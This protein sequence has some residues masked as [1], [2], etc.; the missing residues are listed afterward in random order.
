MQT[1]AQRFYD[2]KTKIGGNR[3]KTSWEY[4]FGAPRE[5]LHRIT[6][7]NKDIR[8][9]VGQLDFAIRLSA[10]AGSGFD[11]QINGAL[12][13]LA[14][15]ID[16]EGVLTRTAC[17]EAEKAILP[18]QSAAKAYDIILASH[19]H[20]DMN[21][22]WGLQ[23][24]VA[25]TLSTF[26]TMLQLMREYP[27]FTFSQSQASVYKIVEDYDP[28]MMDEIK[29]RI[30]E[31]RWECTATAW[32]ETDKNMPNTESLLRHIRYTRDYM[33]DVWG[34]DPKALEVDFSP[35]TFGHAANIP[36]IDSYGN[37]K[38]YYHCRGLDERHVLYNWK[39]PSGKTLLMY[40][41]PYWYNSA[42]VPDIGA[43]L[44]DLSERC[45]GLKTGLIVY[46]VGD[47]GGG[48]TRRDIERALEMQQWPVFPA[49]KFGTFREFF[50]KA[51]TVRD[52]VPVIDKE[53]NFVSTGCYTT[54]SRIKMGNRKSEAALLDAEGFNAISSLVAGYTYPGDKLRRAWQNV[55]FTHF[56]DILTGSCVQESREHA[57]ALY[58]DA[59]SVANTSREN[60][61]RALSNMIDTSMIVVDADIADTQSEGAGVGY[62]IE[63]FS[64]V[65]SPEAG[66]GKVRIYN[67]FNPS[68][69]ERSD[70]VEITVWDWIGDL[71]RIAVAD[72]A[73]NAVPFQLLDRDYVKYWDHQYFRL[74]VEVTVP[75]TGYVT[76]VM[77]EAA[78][79][80]QYPFYYCPFP[81]AEATHP[82][83]TLENDYLKA[84][85]SS[86]D[87]ALLSLID[88]KTGKERIKYGSGGGRLVYVNAERRSN[89]AWRLGRLLGSEPV[90]K[91]LS[92]APMPAGGLRNGFVME[93]EIMS[94]KIVTTVALDRD[95]RA[96]SYTF[97]VN[98]H[99]YATDDKNV[100]V[101][102]YSLPLADSPEAY[103]TDV[104]AGAIRRPSLMNDVSGLQYAAAVYGSG[105]GGGV[106][107]SGSS[108]GSGSG[109]SGGYDGSG[110]AVAL[111]SDC[112][113]GYRGYDDTLSLTLI[114]SSARPDPYP[115]I[116]V[117]KANMW[118]AVDASCPK[119][120][121][122]V[123][124]EFCRPMNYLSTGCHKGELPPSG[125]LLGL[126]AVSTV[127]SSVGLD[128][129]GA[130]LVR[131]YETCGRADSVTIN[132]PFD[133]KKAEL[134]DLC[135]NVIG[136]AS[137]N[138]REITFPIAANS[139]AGARIS[140]K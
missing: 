7:P 11:D 4:T 28:G 62:G 124:A 82:P 113:Y 65:P 99:E 63:H 19:A 16:D 130:L 73:G 52:K 75:A 79:G 2:I 9:I 135:G 100:P 81:R 86:E 24:T 27:E 71:R 118:V 66:K 116:G 104:A 8:R 126:K 69:H 84:H 102:I 133:V 72:H 42:I 40:C 13:I 10:S 128:D 35:D 138:G 20:I 94:S 120:L 97:D 32:V 140:P 139:I 88:K 92:L 25:A 58:A 122:E 51:E 59:M 56:H 6:M 43:G 68:A 61:T 36:E 23:E 60:A 14:K 33:K 132:A 1:L 39:A 55:L 45:A 41:E 76:V 15:S 77:S 74:L 112:K 49:I 48:P 106:G 22:M 78:L 103:Q 53:I 137:I 34:V 29:M 105:D 123:A 85:F 44:I 26:R 131:V 31:G 91:T 17:M 121:Q 67:I 95:A 83:I 111:V 108:G 5:A 46:G 38:Y 50:K 98:W 87:G 109:N 136:D 12:D 57:V 96:L 110:R 54:Q 30:G 107:S 89:S 18:M 47:H 21:W 90:K 134:V 80:A 119:A 127:L 114:N 115:E 64:G 93:Q 3:E 101:L 125:A 70:T 37:V 129:C 117:H